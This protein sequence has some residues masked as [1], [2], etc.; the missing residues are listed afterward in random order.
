MTLTR[1][2]L[3]LFARSAK[4]IF[5]SLRAGARGGRPALKGSVALALVLVAAA[6]AHGQ[7][8]VYI[9][10]TLNNWATADAQWRMEPV[11]D[12]TYALR[13]FFDAGTSRF[14]FVFDGSWNRHLGDAGGGRLV[15][16]GADI[17]LV[18]KQSGFYEITLTLDPPSWSLRRTTPARPV[19]VLD[20]ECLAHDTYRLD[21][22]RT[23]LPK[24]AGQATELLFHA[25][26]VGTGAAPRISDALGS[27]ATLHIPAAGH[28]ELALEVRDA[29]AVERSAQT[30]RLGDGFDLVIGSAARPMHRLSSTAWGSVVDRRSAGMTLKVR[31]F[32]LK[33]PVEVTMNAETVDR[34]MLVR[35][36]AETHRVTI[37]EKG[38]HAFRFDRSM[39]RA[40]EEPIEIERVDVVGSFNG[41]RA[42]ALQMRR[43]S[44]D[45]F[46][47][48][49]ELPDGVH[50]YKFLVNGAVFVEDPRADR[51]FRVSDGNGGFNSGFLIGDDAATLG[52][53]VA[54]GGSAA[55]LKHDPKVAWYFTAIGRD[56]A[57]VRLRTLEKD[58]TRAA[59]AVLTEGGEEAARYPMFR[60]DTSA[61]FEYWA[62]TFPVPQGRVRYRLEASDGDSGLVLGARGAVPASESTT[63]SPE[64]FQA[65]LAPG[66][67]TPD[68]AK[69]MVW[70]Q[71]FPERFRNGDKSNDPKTTVPW[72]HEW[73]KPFKDPRRKPS[74]GPNE[75]ARWN[76]EEKG[77]F[78][79]FIFDR[80][81]GGDL[82]GVREKLPY[83]REL[84]V[85]AIYF[86][87]LFQAESLHKYDA[88][89]FR[90]IDDH[91][92]VHNSL[93]RVRGETTDPATW[94]WSESDRV[95]LDF[96]QEAHRQGFKVIIDGVFNHVG[97]DFWAFKDVLKHGEKSPYAGWFDI[98][99]FEPFHYKAWDR[100]DG[101]LP[102]LKHD[103]ALGLAQPVREHL[104]AVTRRWMDPNGDGDPSDGIDGWRLDVAS[105]INE[106]F[107]K[108]WRKLVKQINP[109][110][111]IVAELWQ[112][113]R[114]W[115]DGRTFD[116][117]MNY[118]F[119]R[120][121]QRFFVN[122]KKATRPTRLD[123]ELR[124]QLAWYAPQVNYVL[125]NLFGS[126]DTDR[127]ASM[128]MNPDLEYD[129]ANRLQDNNPNYIT[130][131]PTSECYRRLLPMV[132]FQMTFLGAPMIYYGD[133]VGMYGADDPSDRKPMFWPDLPNDDPDERIE[134]QVFDHHQRL[135]AIRNAYPALQ[136]GA[137][138]PLMSDD[139]RRIYAYARALGDEVV[140]VVLNNSDKAHRLNIPVH[141]PE[142][143]A[144][145]RLDDPK[146]FDVVPPAADNPA[147]R[148]TLRPRVGASSKW[149]VRNG[150][151]AGGALS[152]RT[153]GVFILHR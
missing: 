133:E 74:T 99:S 32:S 87:P 31:G 15:Q 113:S 120:S 107:W 64:P 61:G 132:T 93:A 22:S 54:G 42:G 50:H 51:R 1:Q 6:R 127:V 125:Q 26:A 45:R 84:G 131:K 129:Q 152:G 81:Y 55:G 149:R 97:R 36:D 68:W 48:L 39:A 46:A 75:G 143:S 103:D 7:T 66:F 148:P 2:V 33:A 19:P 70:Y 115:L 10:G 92:G 16:P 41:W 118:P 94:Q 104:F 76:Y 5:P 73:F 63:Q 153:G 34:P 119:A 20:I 116:A 141:W 95:F 8:A 57:R 78:H 123:A 29:G 4:T 9:A 44:D 114:E 21:G 151:L 109:D 108:D 67:E 18:V 11:D 30:L 137:F 79:Q 140:I 126:H 101:S 60:E 142:G 82:Q 65:Q 38:W 43:E 146:Q 138:H 69:R 27:T 80:R 110:A 83:L 89:D 13:R 145:L 128:F 24:T 150:K 59:M 144:V 98:V 111:Y 85:T 130:A 121:A 112:E 136:L 147:G 96:L 53:A 40:L 100:D 122:N 62:C 56:L 134:Q 35:M 71:I 105:D 52:G 88:S 37:V 12:Q 135:I 102:R 25:R 47:A 90:H 91:F 124:E 117:V 86:N 72:T 23:I 14:K 28:Y 58:A 139:R 49:V 77:E 3:S 106:N 17:D